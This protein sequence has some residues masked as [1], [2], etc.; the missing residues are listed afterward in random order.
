MKE[1]CNLHLILEEGGELIKKPEQEQTIRT[2]AAL[3]AEPLASVLGSRSFCLPACGTGK[4][5]I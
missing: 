4:E 2:A 3:A 5:E 1:T